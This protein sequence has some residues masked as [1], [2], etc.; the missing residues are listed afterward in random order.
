VAA[1]ALEQSALE[2]KDKDQLLQIA[3]AL[4][5][6]A[7]TRLKKADIIGKILESTGSASP[8][9]PAITVNGDAAPSSES[10][11][12]A[13]GSA[14]PAEAVGD[15]GNGSGPDSSASAPGADATSDSSAPRPT[16][17]RRCA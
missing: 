17:T 5:V 16:A 10:S 1:E 13:A 2:S 9:A 12:E 6:K 7:T 8:A 3:N 11:A 15:R 4:G 14:P